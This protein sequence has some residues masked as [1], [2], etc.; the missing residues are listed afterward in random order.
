MTSLWN[1]RCHLDILR[2]CV[3]DFFSEFS[4]KRRNSGFAKADAQFFKMIGGMLSGPEPLL[5]FKSCKTHSTS[6]EVNWS[7]AKVGSS[8]TW[9]RKHPDIIGICS[10]YKF[11]KQITNRGQT[12]FKMH[13]P[14]VAN[15][16]FL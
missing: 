2:N 12:T 4:Q 11:R 1:T 15:A 5:T 13:N 10:L 16:I 6:S 14:W 9:I 8:G 7:A 3:T